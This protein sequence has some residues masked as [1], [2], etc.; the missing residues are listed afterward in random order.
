MIILVNGKMLRLQRRHLR[1][2]FMDG[3][4]RWALMLFCTNFKVIF[5]N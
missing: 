2:A 1:T 3:L 4:R 5:I